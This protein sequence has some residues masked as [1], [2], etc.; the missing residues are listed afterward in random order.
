MR[1]LR[2]KVLK[3]VRKSIFQTVLVLALFLDFFLLYTKVVGNSLEV[4]LRYIGTEF[5]WRAICQ[6][7]SPSEWGQFCKDLY[8]K[9]AEFSPALAITCSLVILIV[10]IYILVLCSELLF[11]LE[12][13]S[14][15]FLNWW[16]NT[17]TVV[18]QAPIGG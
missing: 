4:L 3:A 5:D 12:E 9:R 7:A 13:R 16:R 11:E 1:D 14:Q 15:L 18:K 8:Q 17:E 6:D 10:L 2:P